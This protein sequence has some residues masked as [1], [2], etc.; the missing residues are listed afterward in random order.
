MAIF[1]ILGHIPHIGEGIESLYWLCFVSL[2]LACWMFC[3]FEAG[4][5]NVLFL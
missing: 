2:R 3:F 1:K 5:L 4:L